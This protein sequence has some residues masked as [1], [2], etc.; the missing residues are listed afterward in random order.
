MIRAHKLKIWPDQFGAVERERKTQELR[1]ADRD[2]KVGDCLVLV[3]FD[4]KHDKLTGRYLC[5]EITH[6]HRP[7]DVPRG[8]LEGF[9][10]LS[11]FPCDKLSEEALLGQGGILAPSVEWVKP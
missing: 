3:E 1:K 7:E 4:P 9:V 10:I 8:L 11:I 2:F 5:R 6:I